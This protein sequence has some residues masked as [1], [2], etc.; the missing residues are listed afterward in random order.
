M[1]HVPPDRLAVL[2]ISGTQE[3]TLFENLTRQKFFFTVVNNTAGGMFQEPEV[4]LLVG[5]QSKRLQALLDVVRKSCQPYRQLVS[6]RGIVQGEMVGPPMLEA[7]L[8]GAR[9]YLM[10]VSRFEQF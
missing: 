7:E 9:F 4:C 5:F 3:N 10:N 6:T 2:T 8:G 1:D